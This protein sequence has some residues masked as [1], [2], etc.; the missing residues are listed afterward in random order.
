MRAVPRLYELYLGICLVTE[1]KAGTPLRHGSGKVF[2]ISNFRRV[3]NV[4]YFLLDNST[5]PEFYMPTFRNT[6]FH[7]HRPMKM[8]QTV[9]SKK[10]SYKIQTPGNNLEEKYHLGTI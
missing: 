10:S 8:E 9:C 6:L 3:L 5:A 7:L 1:E 4:L 2:L